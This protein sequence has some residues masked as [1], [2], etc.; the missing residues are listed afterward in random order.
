MKPADLKATLICLA[1]ILLLGESW[2]DAP[3][4]KPKFDSLDE[5]LAAAE[6][7]ERP[8]LIDFSVEWCPSCQRFLDDS[9]HEP[10]I[11]QG[12]KRVVSY[13]VDAEVTPDLAELYEVKSYP[14]F[15]LVNAQG[16]TIERWTGYAPEQFPERLQAALGDPATI[17]EKFARFRIAPKAKDAQILARYH[18]SRH[19]FREAA[20][21]Y[22]AAEK[23]GDVDMSFKIFDAVWS[24]AS[25]PDPEFAPAERRQAAD[26]V[27][28]RS[29]EPAEL[30]RVAFMM[31]RAERETGDPTQAAP[32]I[33][34]AIQST[35]PNDPELARYRTRLLPYRTLFIEH[36]AD[37]ALLQKRQSMPVGW[38]EDPALLNEFAWW[39]FEN[40]LNL[41]EARQLAARGVEFAEP[42]ELRAAI[43]DTE[44]EL[45]QALGECNEAVV[46]IRQAITDDPK[47][48]YYQAQLE[49]FEE[50]LA[51]S[52]S[53]R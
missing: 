4:S 31:L 26:R 47:N 28:E 18:A 48:K 33:E 41:R 53:A 37:K 52:G 46:L 15:V 34:A 43:L 1:L 30:V 6:A 24:G 29:Q 7:Q 27:L 13:A 40:E 17:D 45:C 8:L 42:G 5:A 38:L 49:R 21:Y 39:C 44:A 23:L 32:Y 50:K 35:D 3:A 11:V 19:H 16:S 36:D 20:R 25:A 10:G 14:T 9:T 51:A 22:R 2:A 12:L